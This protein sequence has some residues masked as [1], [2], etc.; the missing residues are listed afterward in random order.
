MSMVTF[1]LFFASPVD[2]ANFACGKNCSAAQKEITA[3]ALGYDDNFLEQWGE[4]AKGVFVG[5]DYPDDPELRETA[6]E[7]IAHCAA[8]CLGYS[9]ERTATVTDLIKQTL[10]VSMSH[11][12]RRLHLLDRRRHPARA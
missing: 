8:P 2:P 10:P 1:A 6:P 5:R 12:D 4:F 7:T 11:R 9:R 3:E